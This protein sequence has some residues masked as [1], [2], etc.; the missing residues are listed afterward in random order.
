MVIMSDLSSKNRG[1][2]L[3][4][5]SYGRYSGSYS[6]SQPLIKIVKRFEKTTWLIGHGK[7]ISYSDD[8]FPEGCYSEKHII[9][10]K[11]PLY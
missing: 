8:E 9:V 11:I 1:E 7:I 3:E 2:R 4:L 10:R 6:R 5:L